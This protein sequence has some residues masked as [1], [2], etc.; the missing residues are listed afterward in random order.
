[1]KKF[2]PLIIFIALV[3]ISFYFLR[4]PYRTY[5]TE[6]KS[7]LLLTSLFGLI[8]SLVNFR[9][10][11]VINLFLLVLSILMGLMVFAPEGR[12]KGVY[13]HIKASLV[14]TGASA[15]LFFEEK[16]S[17]DNFCNSSETTKMLSPIKEYVKTTKC[18]GDIDSFVFAV[19]YKKPLPTETHYCV[20]S[21]G[22]FKSIDSSTYSLITGA[23]T[24][25]R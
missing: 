24:L 14:N 12:P 5:N 3:L 21:T 23:D 22:T 4:D 20:D 13:A 6:A 17:F 9:K 8:T 25:C 7:L 15:A 18:F 19:E 10:A 1:M 11:K 16:K 2:I